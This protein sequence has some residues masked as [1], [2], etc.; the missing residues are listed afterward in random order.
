MSG[1]R[2]PL[3]LVA[4]DDPDIRALIALCLRDDFAIEVAADGLEALEAARR[5]QPDLLVLDVS[6]P[7]A[8]GY[9]VCRTL[10][11]EG[12]SAVVIFLT[13]HGHT[14]ARVQGLDLGAVDYIVKPFQGKELAARARAALRTKRTIDTLAAEAA[15][16]ALTGLLTRGELDGQADEAV[17]VARR[18]GRPLACVML[19]VDRFK[20]VNDELGHAAGDAVLRSVGEAIRTASRL[21]DAPGRF[22]GDEFLVV[23]RETD[24]PGAEAVARRIQTILREERHA[25]TGAFVSVS[26]GVAPWQEHMTSRADLYVAADRALY[27]A[28]ELGRDCGAVLRPAADGGPGVLELLAA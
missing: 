28:K 23:L 5:L 19:D 8:D 9:E 25:A 22:G 13:A 20:S 6:M 11:R 24:L 14:N 3:V 26:I 7:G 16:D 1:D 17:A 21:S 2:S 15:T 10:Q 4:D 27:H 18:H 12:S